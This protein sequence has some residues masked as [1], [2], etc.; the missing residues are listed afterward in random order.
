[1]FYKEI[2]SNF[3]RNLKRIYVENRKD[4]LNS[5]IIYRQQAAFYLGIIGE[6]LKEINND[7]M[8]V[9]RAYIVGNAI[10]DQ[11]ID[12]F[13]CYCYRLVHNKEEE[14]VNLCYTLIHQGD[15]VNYNENAF[16]VLI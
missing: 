9:R 2:T 11:G 3:K 13:N 15:F 12:K 5:G 10:S 8:V 4:N 16:E 6:N 14:T 7:S 1:M